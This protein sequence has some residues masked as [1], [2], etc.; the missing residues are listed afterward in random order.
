MHKTFQSQHE[1]KEVQR[2]VDKSLPLS[3][4]LLTFNSDWETESQFS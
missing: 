4:E 2:G 1:G 3:E